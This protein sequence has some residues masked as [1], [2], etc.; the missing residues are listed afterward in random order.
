V[1]EGE[2]ELVLDSGETR[3]LMPRDIAMQRGTMHARRTPSKS[4]WSRM[5]FI[6]QDAK[7]LEVNSKKLTDD[8]G[9]IEVQSTVEFSTHKQ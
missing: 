7:Q 6:L 2:V 5:I 4:N 8:Y 9:G 3:L 1:L